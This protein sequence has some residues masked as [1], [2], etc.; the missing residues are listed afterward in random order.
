MKFGKPPVV[1]V[2]VDFLFES[3]AGEPE[4]DHKRALQFIHQFEADYPETE[5]VFTFPMEEFQRFS[6]GPAPTSNKSEQ[7]PFAIRAF[8]VNRSRFIQNSKDLLRCIFVRTDENDYGGFKALKAEA[9]SKLA[10]YIE[11]FRP[12]KMIGFKL[13][14][15]DFFRI[16]VKDGKAELRDFFT[17]CVEPDEAI[18]GTIVRFR[19]SFTTRTEDSHDYMTCELYNV[20]KLGDNDNPGIPFRMEWSMH[21]YKNISWDADVLGLRLQQA[22]AHLL[23]C[24]EKSFTAEGLA[25]FDPLLDQD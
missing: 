25:L 6:A 23:H 1:E 18:F 22:H 3:S 7:V 15:V 2:S 9:M 8:P 14:Y 20:R 10:S 4:W 5:I 21:A 24:F 17:I 11:C 16:P 13:G 12:A 19:K